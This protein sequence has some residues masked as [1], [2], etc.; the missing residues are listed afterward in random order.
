MFSKCPVYSSTLC[1]CQTVLDLYKQRGFK[2]VPEP[3]LAAKETLPALRL[4]IWEGGDELIPVQDIG[5]LALQEVAKLYTVS[6]SL[7]T[8]SA[9]RC[10]RDNTS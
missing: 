10:C 9:M 7:S 2:T 6:K 5:K 1:L 8:P 4:T 3:M